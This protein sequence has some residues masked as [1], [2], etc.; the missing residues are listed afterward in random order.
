MSPKWTVKA[1]LCSLMRL[2]I[3]MARSLA[4][5]LTIHGE[6]ERP[7][8]GLI[9]V[10]AATANVNISFPSIGEAFLFMWN[11]RFV[12]FDYGKRGGCCELPFRFY[13]RLRRIARRSASPICSM[14]SLP[15]M[16]GGATAIVSPVNGMGSLPRGHARKLGAHETGSTRHGF[17]VE[18]TGESDIAD[19]NDFR[20]AS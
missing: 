13:C 14:S 5:A 20:L 18:C 16:N 19:V 2:A 12:G 3:L 15:E 17:E 11:V 1:G 10:S 4:I 9:C 7:S 8:S 6:P